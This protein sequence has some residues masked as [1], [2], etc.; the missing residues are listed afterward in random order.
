MGDMRDKRPSKGA[1]GRKELADHI[2]RMTEGRISRKQ[3]ETILETFLFEIISSLDRNGEMQ[4]HKFGTLKVR[5]K[6][7]RPGR[8]PKT[9]QAY[10]IKARKTVSFYASKNL[11]KILINNQNTE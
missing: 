1:V 10:T 3:G 2:Y 11:K 8:N 9:K 5:E 6:S 4:L 7:A